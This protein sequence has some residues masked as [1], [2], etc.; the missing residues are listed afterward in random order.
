MPS[1]R[2]REETSE[3]SES[4]ATTDESSHDSLL[5]AKS[6]AR[7]KRVWE[8][9][10]SFLKDKTKYPKKGTREPTEAE[11]LTYMRHLKKAGRKPSSLCSIFSILGTQHN[12]K[13]GKVL[14]DRYPSLWL[15]LKNGK[16][17]FATKKA[18]TFSQEEVLGFIQKE[19][20]ETDIQGWQDK[21]LATISFFGGL[22]S[23]E[24]RSINI[25]SIAA[26]PD[27]SL[28]VNY[29][30]AKRTAEKAQ[31]QFIIPKDEPSFVAAVKTHVENLSKQKIIS[32]PLARRVSPSNNFQQ[33]PIG[34]N[35][36][37]ALPKRIAKAIGKDPDGYS[38]H[39][40]RRSAALCAAD[41]GASVLE[42]KRHFGWTSDAMPLVYVDSS[43][44]QQ[45]N[46]ANY[47]SR[48][49]NA[50]ATAPTLQDPQPLPAPATPQTAHPTRF[51]FDFNVNV[52]VN[53]SKS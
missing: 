39:S 4:E 15:R 25:E 41:A 32:G 1:K 35:S 20:D 22:R 37:Y 31:R 18:K 50:P 2:K 11:Y 8:E 23:A 5:P 17:D 16:K 51:T 53:T 24:L 3:D 34:R 42:L 38:G 12:S 40:M 48:T 30:G 29:A 45:Q 19:C 27:G 46:M 47:L 7:Y 26:R 36:F 52:N 13:Y 14:K 21:A 28:F 43:V 33:T 49:T 9:F 6:E 44:Q 10:V